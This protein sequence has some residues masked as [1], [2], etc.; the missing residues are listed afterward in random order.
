MLARGKQS[1][2]DTHQGFKQAVADEAATLREESYGWEFLR[3]VGYIYENE[4]KQHLGGFLGIPGMIASWKEKGHIIKEVVGAVKQ[5][6]MVE[7]AMMDA[8]EAQ[9]DEDRA[10]LEAEM[11]NQVLSSSFICS[12]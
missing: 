1:N 5:E 7:Q 4:A 11:T 8:Q 12:A 10:R 2:R 3:H 9:D 6:L